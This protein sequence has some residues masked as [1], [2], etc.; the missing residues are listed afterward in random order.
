[1]SRVS[2]AFWV[3]SLL[4]CS[5][6]S[7]SLGLMTPRLDK[8]FQYAGNESTGSPV[9]LDG[10]ALKVPDGCRSYKLG[11]RCR[12][13]SLLL[14]HQPEER[15]EGMWSIAKLEGTN[16]AR[17]SIGPWPA[18]CL[19]VAAPEAKTAT[20]KVTG[21]TTGN[22]HVW[23]ECNVMFDVGDPRVRMPEPCS[24]AIRFE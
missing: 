24:Q 9:T 12:K 3:L 7:G 17:C 19:T 4:G 13:A 15:F 16:P 23:A 14:S 6:S 10:H 20:Y 2:S 5:E 22:V 11:V 1:M 8:V 21:R 18:E